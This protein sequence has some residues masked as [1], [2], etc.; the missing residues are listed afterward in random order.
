MISNSLGAMPRAAAQSLAEYADMWATRGVRAWEERWW[1]LAGDGGRIERSSR[2]AGSVSMHERDHGREVALSCI[3][4]AARSRIVCT[5]MDSSK[6][7]YRGQPRLR[8]RS[9]RPQDLSVHAERTPPPSTNAR[10]WSASPVLFPSSHR[11]SRPDIEKAHAVGAGLLDGYQSAG[12]IPVDVGALGGLSS[13]CL[14]GF[15][16]PNAFLYTPD[17][18]PSRPRLTGW[19]RVRHRS[20]STS[21]PPTCARTEWR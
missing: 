5:A 10:Q 3:M 6:I 21:T 4:P 7:F 18:G 13:D 2:A 11:R 15:R 9:C 16:G 20:R 12:I 14:S 1:E 8:A 17:E 19:L